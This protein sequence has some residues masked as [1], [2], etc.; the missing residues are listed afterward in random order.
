MA[1]FHAY[2]HQVADG[3]ATSVVRPSD[4]NSGHVHAITL[5][6]NTAGVSTA[7]GTNLVYQ[8]GNNVTL[9]ANQGAGVATIV[10]SVAN[11]AAS[12]HTH[13]TPVLYMTNLS[14]TANSAS[15]GLSLSLAAPSAGVSLLG[16]VSGNSTV[17]DDAN[18]S[19]YFQ[20]GNNVTLSGTGST[21]V[22]SAAAGGGAAFTAPFYEPNPLGNNTSASSFGQN[23]LY[24]VP[25]K[26]YVNISMSAVN[27]LVSMNATTSSVS[28]AKSQT[29]SYGLYSLGTG[30]Q[31]TQLYLMGSSSMALIASGSSTGACGFTM[32]QGTT[33]ATL[34][35]SNSALTASLAGIKNI[36][37]LFATSI[38][39]G[40][41]YY[42][43]YAQSTSS[44]NAASAM[45]ISNI[46]LTNITNASIPQFAP[47]GI[48]ASSASVQLNYNGF[49]YSATSA[50]WPAS[51]AI[52]QRSIASNVRNYFYLDA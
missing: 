4:W 19:F 5:S 40:Y 18:G 32:S 25:F 22:V 39:G 33:S 41:E 27:I 28:H 3:T 50:A 20:G 26:P 6:G 7:S 8:G 23:T 16:N 31:G 45:M 46:V 43:G 30:T 17:A 1:L 36:K 10:M 2:T 38:P 24:F 11:S 13:G 48:T 14:G 29:I 51:F 44:T 34:S 12:D 42:L 52:S 15:N 49:M 35:S 47:T 37:L 9:S 21:I